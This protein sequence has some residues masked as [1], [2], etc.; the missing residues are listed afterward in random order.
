M[1]RSATAAHEAGH[2]I[3][4]VLL[5]LNVRLVTILSDDPC[6]RSQAFTDLS[7]PDEHDLEAAAMVRLAGQRALVAFGE[8]DVP[9]AEIGCRRDIQEARAFALVL[10]DGHEVQARSVLR[11]LRARVDDLLLEH[12]LGLGRLS[13]ELLKHWTLTGPEIAAA[14]AGDAGDS[15]SNAGPAGVSLSAASGPVPASLHLVRSK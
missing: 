9:G 7:D 2:A 15:A 3:V 1:T 13:I 6:R 14:L 12:H 5:G 11:D 8:L 10:A 4:A